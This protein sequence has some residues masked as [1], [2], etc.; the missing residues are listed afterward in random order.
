MRHAG[1]SGGCERW[2]LPPCPAIAFFLF[3]LIRDNESPSAAGGLTP[4]QQG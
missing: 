2:S 1:D 3:V 4:I